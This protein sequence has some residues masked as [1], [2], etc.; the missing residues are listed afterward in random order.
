M[1]LGDFIKFKFSKLLINYHIESQNAV[2][3]R[4]M[5]LILIISF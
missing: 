2:Y 3:H 5:P 1:G 4:I